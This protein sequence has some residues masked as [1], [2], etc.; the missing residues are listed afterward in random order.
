MSSRFRSAYRGLDHDQQSAVKRRITR[1]AK[2]FAAAD[3]TLA[4]PGSSLVAVGGA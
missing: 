2:P 1:D 4:M 3:G